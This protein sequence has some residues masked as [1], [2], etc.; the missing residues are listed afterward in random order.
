M[1]EK[2][3]EKTNKETSTMNNLVIFTSFLEANLETKFNI[4]DEIKQ[5]CDYVI[6]L[7]GGYNIASDAG[8]N[9]DLLMG[10][11]DSLSGDI[12]DNVPLERFIPE[13]DYSDL[14]LALQKAVE[15][16]AK[17][18]TIVGG[19]G[20]RLDH[21]IANIQLLSQYTD[22]FESLT[23]LD[24]R[25]K[26]F[27]L[28]KAQMSG[29]SLKPEPGSYLSFFSLSEKCTGLTLKN[30]K[31]PL[32]DHTLPRTGSLCVSNEFIE[33]KDAVISVKNGTLLVVISKKN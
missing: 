7:D 4:F 33:K 20:G 26:C 29:I 12:P 32:N 23:M 10:D 15:L 1:L 31:Y 25:N 9:T 16:D 14:E 17:N 27:V 18:V 13:K 30:V 28:N 2:I 22:N 21:T 24:G 6:C 19:I 11:M 3:S 5:H 8:F